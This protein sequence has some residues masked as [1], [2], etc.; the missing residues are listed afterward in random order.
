MNKLIPME[1]I[2]NKIFLIRG[3]KVMVDHD[4]ADLYQVPTKRIKEQVKR[5]MRRFPTDFMFQLTWEELSSLRSQIAALEKAGSQR[6]RHSKYLPYAFTEQGVAMLSTVLNSRRAIDINIMIMRAFVRLRKVLA[7]NKDLTYL[8]K[9]L[10][11]KVDK[12]DVEIGLII[13]T[14]EKMIATESK[15]KPRIGFRA[16]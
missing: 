15:P 11:H 14:I 2:E 5:N 4:L 7:T 10:K 8:F 1:Q 13:K 9:E 3:Q 16:E 12:H 6:G